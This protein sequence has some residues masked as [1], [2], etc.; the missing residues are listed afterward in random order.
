MATTNKDKASS[1]PL[2]GQDPMTQEERAAFL[3]N[4]RD[5]EKA[6]DA[7]VANRGQKND[8]PHEH[9]PDIDDPQHRFKDPNH[10]IN[11]RST[12]AHEEMKLAALGDRVQDEL[13]SPFASSRRLEVLQ[14]AYDQQHAVLEERKAVF[15]SMDA[16]KG[17]EAAATVKPNNGPEVKLGADNKI[18]WH[19][20]EANYLNYPLQ[21]TTEFKRAHESGLAELRAR[22]TPVVTF[23]P[24]VFETGARALFTNAGD[25]PT[26]ISWHKKVGVNAYA[27]PISQQQLERTTESAGRSDTRLALNAGQNIKSNH[28]GTNSSA[29]VGEIKHDAMQL[30]AEASQSAQAGELAVHGHGHPSGGMLSVLPIL[31]KSAVTHT[32]APLGTEAIFQADTALEVMNKAE[33]AFANGLLTKD[34][35]EIINSN[36]KATAAEASAAAIIP[37]P[38]FGMDKIVQVGDKKLVAELVQAGLPKQQAEQYEMGSMIESGHR[39]AALTVSSIANKGD[40]KQIMDADA[41]VPLSMALNISQAQLKQFGA[42]SETLGGEALKVEVSRNPAF[43]DLAHLSAKKIEKLSEMAAAGMDPLVMDY[44]HITTTSN[45]PTQ[46]SADSKAAFMESANYIMQSGD[47]DFRVPGN[48]PVELKASVEAFAKAYEFA[49][50]DGGLSRQNQTTLKMTMD[51]LSKGIETN[52]LQ[53]VVAKYEASHMPVAAANDAEHAVSMQR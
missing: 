28:Q 39:M 38:G 35:L 47:T 21:L 4:A 32:L 43:E 24:A 19:K 22:H 33:K 5:Q 34:Q 12:I 52:Q 6:Y 3:Q 17:S 42:M 7:Y 13:N 36:T 26:E 18:A 51:T 16:S 50:E 29:Q 9:L 49:A 10:P 41:A 2:Y 23:K 15:V 20:T 40:V 1:Y 37:E 46:L 44:G 8:Y 45:R 30:A 27:S 14:S 53:G 48:R 25:G 11:I 31:S